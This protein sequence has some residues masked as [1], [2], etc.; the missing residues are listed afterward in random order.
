MVRETN[1]AVVTAGV[2]ALFGTAEQ[3]LRQRQVAQ[4]GSSTA[5]HAR[6]AKARNTGSASHAWSFHSTSTTRPTP[7]VVTCSRYLLLVD[8]HRARV[9][10]P[11]LANAIADGTFE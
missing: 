3:G 5:R 4:R 2:G 11:A 9:I 6:S 10:G 8:T 7:A 1:V